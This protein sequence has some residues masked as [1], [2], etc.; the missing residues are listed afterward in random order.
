MQPPTSGTGCPV[1]AHGGQ[2][3]PDGP[4]GVWINAFQ[5]CFVAL[6]V[7]HG[8]LEVAQHPDKDPET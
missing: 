6:N 4:E 2:I 8:T 5:A 3:R 1:T 7:P